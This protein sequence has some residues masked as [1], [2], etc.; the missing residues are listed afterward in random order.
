MISSQISLFES[1][2]IHLKTMISKTKV[3]AY[4]NRRRG[5]KAGSVTTLAQTPAAALLKGQKG[6]YMNV[7]KSENKGAP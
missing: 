1:Q 7:Q 4:N 3:C 5:V 6:Y 2:V